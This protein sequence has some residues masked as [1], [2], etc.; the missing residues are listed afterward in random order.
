LDT[1]LLSFSYD[2]KRP[3]KILFQDEARFGRI[4]EPVKCWAP[5]SI[6]PVVS[7]QFIREYIYVYATVCPESGEVFSLILPVCNTDAMTL[8]MDELSVYYKDFKV[9]VFMDKAGWH[10]SKELMIAD[11]VRILH[12]PPYSPEL[13]PAEHLWEHIREKYFRN[14]MSDSLDDLENKLVNALVD[15]ENNNETIKSL[16][17]FKWLYF[18]D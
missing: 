15:V 18:Y 8:F 1:T 9:I 2:D 12:L 7:K 14:Q 17:N 5:K 13:N 3:V 10:T 4:N 11:N 16:T 6:R